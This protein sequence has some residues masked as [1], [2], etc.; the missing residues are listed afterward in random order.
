MAHVIGPA[1]PDAEDRAQENRAG[2]TGRAGRRQLLLDLLRASP[3]PRSILS[4]AQELKVHAN[5]VR[6]HL[7][8]LE[9]AGQVEQLLADAA[10]P[11]RPPVLFR[12]TRRMDP[13][14]P[15]NYRLLAGMLA[16]HLAASTP[17]PAAVGAELGRAWGARLLDLP[18]LGPHR[19]GRIRR[20]EAL[21][22]MTRILGNAGFAPEPPTG[23]RDATIRLRHCPFLGLVAGGV[24][25]GA[26]GIDPDRD[27]R[28]G[29]G[30]DAV[31]C[32]LHLGLMQGALAAMH[33]PVTVDRL[34]PFV[35]PDL[36]VAHLAPAAST[37]PAH[38]EA[39]AS[40]PGAGAPAAGAV[41]GAP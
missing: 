12:A 8:A 4:L 31:I 17:D 28:A 23:P 21:A 2:G 34:D 11:G 30:Q 5:T 35:E 39:A 29:R 9:H 19:G 3:Q 32:S 1:R 40:R 36:C 41:P 24:T 38:R 27:G 18:T 6:F 25:G 37:A 33:G 14:G 26:T 20:G 13:D 16:S 22:Y 7:E 15:T 10:G